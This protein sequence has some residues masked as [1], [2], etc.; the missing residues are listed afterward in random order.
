MEEPRPNWIGVDLD[1]TLAY[2][3]TW[4]GHEHIGEPIPAML[5][6]VKDWLDRGLTVKI[7]TARVCEH[8]LTVI[9]NNETTAIDVITPSRATALRLQLH[10]PGSWAAKLMRIFLLNCIRSRSWLK[11]VFAAI[12]VAAA[13]GCVS[14]PPPG[15]VIT[16]SPIWTLK[17][18]GSPSLAVL[19][20]AHYVASHDFFGPGSGEK[21]EGISRVFLSKDRGLSWQQQSELRGVFWSSLFVHRGALYLMGPDKGGGNIVIRRSADEGRTWTTP[22][23]A[24][25][26]LLF[27][28]KYG[29]APSPTVE[30]DGRLWRIV[31]N[32]L[33]SAPTDADLLKASSWTMS[34]SPRSHKKWLGGKFEGWGEGSVVV[35]PNSNVVNVM[36]VRYLVPGEDK[37]AIIS[38]NKE[39]TKA[40]AFSEADFVPMPGARIKFTVRHDPVSHLYWSLTSYLLPEDFGPKT[41]L[42]RNT[43]ALVSSPDLQHWTM[44]SVVLHHPDVQRHGFQYVDWAIEGDDIIAISRTAW[45][46]GMGGPARQHDA[47]YLTF[48]RFKNFRTVF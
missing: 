17:F 20:N 10:A 8:G 3:D 46:D 28:G 25:S 18:I 7:F 36:K 37:A 22:R 32:S 9:R 38:F 34:D 39:G 43:I 41:D 24:N 6:R 40:L 16:H 15:V 31:S 26:G 45:P 21:K 30:H 1:G 42:R 47:N 23:D 19:P 44:R 13:P 29:A 2:H 11:L 5:Q 48:H 33:L 14:S 27:P 12:G 35:G 4:K